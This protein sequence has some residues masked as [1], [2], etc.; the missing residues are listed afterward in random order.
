MDK[1]AFLPPL[2]AMAAPLMMAPV[3]GASSAISGL[4][5]SRARSKADK[6]L[7]RLLPSS[8]P[9]VPRLVSMAELVEL[10]RVLWVER[11]WVRQS[12]MSLVAPFLAL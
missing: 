6:L 1:Q 9:A 10:V 7:E 8:D 11:F 2:A 4:V 12:V 3:Y 5:S